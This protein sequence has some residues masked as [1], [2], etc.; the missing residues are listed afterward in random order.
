MSE[1]DTG[2]RIGRI[3]ALADKLG[4]DNPDTLYLFAGDLGEGNFYNKY[5]GIPEITAYTIAGVDAAVPGNH[6]FDYS[7]DFFKFWA[8]NSSYPLICANIDFSD[9][10]LNET[11]KDYTI[12]NA[13]SAKVGIFGIITPQ[14]EKYVTDTDGIFLYKDT[15]DLSESVVKKLQHEGCDVI[16]A[17]SHQYGDEDE[18]LAKSVSGISLI[19]GGHDHLSW[20]KTVESRDGNQTLIVHSGK[21]GEEISRISLIFENSKLTNTNIERYEITEDLPDD[22]SVTSYVMPYYY[23]YTESL[24]EPVGIT[25]VPLDATYETLRNGESN[26]G[27]FITDTITKNIYGSEIALIN[28]GSIRG[29]YTIP[30]GEISYLTLTTLLPFENMI[31]NLEMSGSDI[32]DA[33]ERSASAL[34]GQNDEFESDER[35]PKGGFLQV[36]GVHFLI[37]TNSEPF[38]SDPVNGSVLSYGNRIENLSVVTDEGIIPIDLKK[39]Y[40]VSVNNYL[41]GGGDG[42]S[43]LAEIADDRKYN[44][45]INLI[46]LLADEIGTNSPITPVTD[47]RIVVF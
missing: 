21:Y 16:I 27:D 43:N 5:N 1:N 3:S 9:T 17:L 42:Y 25:T 29:D 39:T 26:A 12:V 10:A 41:A 19:V 7:A 40:T 34:K 36:S 22:S 30:A 23:E 44:T 2:S 35:T 46:N 14:L 18:E 11:V 37:N 15:K 20:N 33:L 6:A 47:G 28:S 24:S 4:E 8:L 38:R 13:G 31:V 45:E 32:K